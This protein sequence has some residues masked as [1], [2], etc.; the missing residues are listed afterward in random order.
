MGSAAATSGEMRSSPK[1]PASSD[2]EVAAAAA[3]GGGAVAEPFILV[4]ELVWY[5]EGV[6]CVVRRALRVCARCVSSARQVN[7]GRQRDW[8]EF[9]RA[10]GVD[11]VDERVTL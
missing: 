4:I 11:A 10:A 3:A 6:G 9:D 2:A 1:R 5:G 7:Q 8:D